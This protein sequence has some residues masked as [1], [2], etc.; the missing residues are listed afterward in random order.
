MEPIYGRGCVL[1]SLRGRGPLNHR[2]YRGLRQ[3][4]LEG[5]LPPG[6]RLP[7]T[8]DLAGDLGLSRN[9]VLMAFDKLLDEG[10][11]EARVGSGTYVSQSLPDAA[12]APWSPRPA[13][14]V[15]SQ[16]PRLSAH[17]R[18]VMALAPLPAPGAPIK[19]GL[20]YDFRYGIPAIADFP[21]DIWSRALARRARAVSIRTLRYGRALGFGPLREAIAH[22]VTR[23]RGVAATPDQVVVINGSQ[24]AL[25]VV[26]RLLLDPGDRVVV[27]E[28][29]YQGARNVFAAAGARLVPVPVDDA[30]LDVSRLPRR[31]SPRLAYVTPSHQ[32]PLGG[33]M[34]LAR[35]LELLRWAEET[36][37]YVLE[38]D[39][40]SE[41]RYE[42]RPVE[43]V[44]GLDRSARVL[45]VGTFSKILFP[46]LRLGYLIVP[47]AMVPAVA[48]LKFL[49]DLH[50]P[51]FEQEVLA[52]FISEGHFERYLR[53][54]RGRN[55]ARR[56]ALLDALEEH[57]G[58]GVEVVGANAGVHL[59]AW[60]RG[61]EFSQLDA[62]RHRAADSGVGIYGLGAYYLRQP[63][64]AGLLF[65]YACLT[66][67]DIRE[68]I[69]TL[70]TVLRGFF[71]RQPRAS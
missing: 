45:Y 11:V 63:R 16:P 34:P 67:R 59:V 7:S 28:P 14:R 64:E 10:Y 57:L 36:G 26:A 4:I 44:Q 43:A 68:G 39:Y 30:G 60:L 8:R 32:F 42:G 22:Y 15:P 53:R 58:D 21:H 27:E 2:L 62:I 47:Q 49:M 5:R 37:A 31:G 18:R 52:D 66:E 51:T 65:G 35:R 40:D 6:T 69:R 24:Q 46:S 23:A 56:S 48:A 71:R 54:S 33:L 50:T 1:V 55:A 29:C 19:T 17:A 38:D 12:I 13:V 9:V 25:D 20:R 3:G 61:V 70:S 41:F